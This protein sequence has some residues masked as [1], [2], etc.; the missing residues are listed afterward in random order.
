MIV[1]AL[2]DINIYNEVLAQVKIV[3][4][5]LFYHTCIKILWIDRS[6]FYRIGIV[7]NLSVYENVNEFYRM[8][9]YGPSVEN[10][11]MSGTLEKEILLFYAQCCRLC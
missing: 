8:K 4:C 3:C 6:V 5:I 7:A 9:N 2:L 10:G 11:Y 1:L